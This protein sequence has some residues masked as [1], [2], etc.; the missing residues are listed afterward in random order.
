[1]APLATAQSRTALLMRWG[2]HQVCWALLAA[3][4]SVKVASTMGMNRK[5][6]SSAESVKLVQK[7]TRPRVLS[8]GRGGGT[9][10]RGMRRRAG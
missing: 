5:Q 1:M 9:D 7:M 3:G 10:R 2:N 8:A 4:N 6:A